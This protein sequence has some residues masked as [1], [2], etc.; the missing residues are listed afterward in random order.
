MTGD[1]E[2]AQ[3]ATLRKA[4]ELGINWIDTAAGY[5]Q[6]K[7]ETSIGRAIRQIPAVD[8]IH[9]ATKVRLELDQLNDIRGA[10]R[11]SV[12]ASLNRLGVSRVMLLQLHNGLTAQRGDEAFTITPSDVLRSGGVL[13]AFRE[14]RDNGLIQHF[15][16]TGTGQPAAMREVV[17]SGGFDTMQVPYHLLNPSA[18]QVMPAGFEETD[19]GNIIADCAAMNM[20]VFAIRVFAAGALLGQEPSAHTHKTPFFPLDLY[21]RDRQRAS[22][23]ANGG[24]LK[25]AALRFVLDDSRVHSAIIG[26]GSPDQ[27]EELA[28]KTNP[29]R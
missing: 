21:L 29:T 19:Y 4:I 9:I 13:D 15:G 20:G 2:A 5:G 3:V 12:E 1:D 10:V 25:E 14:L 24:S 28:S 16:L 22:Q 7:S 6:G 11:R 18:A 23:L 27:V 8:P 26:F 17:R